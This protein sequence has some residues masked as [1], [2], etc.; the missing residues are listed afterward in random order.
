MC[1]RC[2]L[3]RARAARGSVGRVYRQP[4]LLWAERAGLLPDG[5]VANRHRRSTEDVL[6]LDAAFTARAHAARR[7]LHLLFLDLQTAYPSTNH[8]L[9]LNLLFEL[10]LR[11]PLWLRLHEIYDG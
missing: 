5:M 3:R 6:L 9:M 10:G 1:E 2:A 8:S 4:V 11:G 7:E